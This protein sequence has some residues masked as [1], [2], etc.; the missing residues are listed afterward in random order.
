MKKWSLLPLILILGFFWT[1]GESLAARLEVMPP[2]I[3]ASL[4]PGGTYKATIYIVDA[5]GDSTDFSWQLIPDRSWIKPERISDSGPAM[6]KITITSENPSESVGSITVVSDIGESFITVRRSIEEGSPQGSFS[7]WV[8]P[9]FLSVEVQRVP[10]AEVPA[11]SFQVGILCSGTPASQENDNGTNQAPPQVPCTVSTDQSWLQVEGGNVACGASFNITIN[12]DQ[13]LPEGL[14]QGSVVV[15]CG[16]LSQEVQ[17]ELQVDDQIED[18]LVVSP[19]ALEVK[20]PAA[21]PYPRTFTLRLYNANPEGRAF[22]FRATSEVSWLRVEPQ[23]GFFA[24]GEGG[25]ISLVVDPTGL[26]AG[27]YQGTVRFFSDLDE[28]SATEGLA[29]NVSLTILP[30]HTLEVFPGGLFWSLE[31]KEDGALTGAFPQRLHV[32]AGVEGWS[33]ST[34]V[35]WLRLTPLWPAPGQSPEGFFQVELVP[36]ALTSLPCGRYE[37]E[38]RI[39]GKEEGLFRSVPVMVEIRRPGEEVVLPVRPPVFT[40][41]TPHFARLEAVEASF[42]RLRFPAEA[43]PPADPK[44]C[45]ALSG[46][47]EEGSCLFRNRVYLLLKSPLLWPGKVFSWR[48]TE[49]RFALIET[50]GAPVAGADELYTTLGPVGEISL[51]PV[52]LLGLE[53]EIFF[54]VR[55]GPSYQEARPLQEVLV[56]IYTP[57][58][59]WRVTDYFEGE[60]YLHPDTLFLYRMGEGWAGCW[61]LKGECVTPVA[62]TPGDGKTFLYELEFGTQ[63]YWFTYQVKD[64][65]PSQMEGRWRFF[66]GKK[67]SAWEAFRAEKT[68][69]WP[70]EKGALNNL[71]PS[72]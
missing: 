17:V 71:I 18:L 56:Q 47:W 28:S 53:G 15:A 48:P 43:A 1:V 29:L 10:G 27:D 68:G 9:S 59:N 67:W 44:A 8:S 32:Y 66:D 50:G 11:R 38:I 46:R 37:G 70:T 55:V 39:T 64:L 41:S 35:P 40:Q 14:Y 20:V 24:S 42:I 25:E 26:P 19:N 69:L 21:E 31:K 58:G 16:G 22:N 12:P 61:K 63:G 13:D 62:V 36:E 57:A 45:K 7:F 65:S 52:R 4:S 23:R 72:N 6:V 51:G 34:D 2:L 30:W 3:K 49:G 54:E 60:T 5:D 33:V